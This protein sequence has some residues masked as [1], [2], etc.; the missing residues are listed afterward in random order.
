MT[1]VENFVETDNTLEI[2]IHLINV[3]DFII[4]V[5]YHVHVESIYMKR[6]HLISR[7][8]SHNYLSVFI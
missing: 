1:F 4:I 3:R 2:C 8:N 5:L 6:I 7:Y